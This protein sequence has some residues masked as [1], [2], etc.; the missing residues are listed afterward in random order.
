MKTRFF[1]LD[2]ARM[3]SELRSQRER[4]QAE[5]TGVLTEDQKALSLKLVEMIESARRESNLLLLDK[6]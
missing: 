1:H 3:L 6:R 4:I 2:D 5:L